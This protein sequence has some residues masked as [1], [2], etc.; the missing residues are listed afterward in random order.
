ME[1]GTVSVTKEPRRETF[2]IQLRRLFDSVKRP[3]GT[4]HTPREVAE[5][6]TRRGHRVSRSYLYAL[7][8]GE[9]EP[10]HTLVQALADYF[11]VPLDY[12][13]N[14]ERGQ[15]LNRQYQL[16]ASLGEHN[17]RQIACRARGLSPEKLRSVLDFI[18]FEASRDDQR[19]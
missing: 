8:K 10:S 2:A 16:L 1:G 14:S 4:K 3:D 19:S 15:E 17:V 7:L 6:I 12:F 11:T 9:S 13:S 18:D 5:E